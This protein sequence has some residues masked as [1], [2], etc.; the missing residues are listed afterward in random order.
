MAQAEDVRDILQRCTKLEGTC[1][2]LREGQ[3]ELKSSVDD[4]SQWLRRTMY[5]T[6]GTPGHQV[7]LDRLEQRWRF[8]KWLLGTVVALI[9]LAV[10][11]QSAL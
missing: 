1:D 10:A 4:L 8:G 5:G 11:A 3:A 6:N 9:G 2:S 7:R